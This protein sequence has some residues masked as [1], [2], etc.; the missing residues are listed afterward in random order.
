MVVVME[1]AGPQWASRNCNTITDSNQEESRRQ[2]EG[3]APAAYECNIT[4]VQWQR[5]CSATL[6][7]RSDSFKT[8]KNGITCKKKKKKF[9]SKNIIAQSKVRLN[10]SLLLLSSLPCI[11]ITDTQILLV[12]FCLFEQ[13][14]ESIEDVLMMN[15]EVSVASLAQTLLKYILED[16]GKCRS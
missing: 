3:Q 10:E 9:P 1:E 6:F 4:F 8:E 12:L 14:F 11:W 16:C 7:H 5:I 15:I 13:L 2:E